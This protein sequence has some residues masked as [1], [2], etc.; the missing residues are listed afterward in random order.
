MQCP[1]LRCNFK[2]NIRPT[3]TSHRSRHHR[4]CSLKDFRTVGSLGNTEVHRSDV[5]LNDCEG[6]VSF[7]SDVDQVDENVDSDTL[8]HNE[9]LFF[10]V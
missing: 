6:A 3:F 7:E 4:H 5:E 9:E 1:I 2:T 8:K 10:C